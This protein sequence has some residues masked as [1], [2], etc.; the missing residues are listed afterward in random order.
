MPKVVPEYKMKARERI[1]EAALEVFSRKGYHEARMEDIAEKLGVSKRT[2]Y[3]YYKN[4]EEL[5]KAI[6]AGA[7]QAMR[8]ML[9]ACFEDDPAGAACSNFFGRATDRP[10]SGFDFEIIAAA[11]RN[12]VLKKMM[13][14]LSKRETEIIAHFLDVRKK[15]GTLPP[16]LEPDQMARIL[17]ALYRGLT[18]DLILG[19]KKEE[20]RDAWTEA[21][22]LLLASPST[23]RS[24]E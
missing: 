16:D 1:V 21:T 18:A 22:N 23:K 7:P 9:Q 3:L 2:L 4:K 12:S 6:C 8:E 15:K 10:P 19:A 5:F 13:G 11:S 17:I 20:I 14:E 24:K